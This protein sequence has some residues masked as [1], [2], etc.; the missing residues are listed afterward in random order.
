MTEVETF[1]HEE[2]I[3]HPYDAVERRGISMV[4]ALVFR[5]SGPG[6]SPGR[7]HGVVFVG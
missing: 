2:L 4:S 6:S 1:A 3:R 7:G 5:S